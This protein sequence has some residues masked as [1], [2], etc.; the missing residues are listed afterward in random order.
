[1][2]LDSSEH[3][4]LLMASHGAI[5]ASLAFLFNGYNIFAASYFTAIDRPDISLLI[6]A[7]HGLVLIPP[8]IIL[9][10]KVLDIDGIWFATPIA[11]LTTAIVT[12]F[13][14]KKSISDKLKT[15]S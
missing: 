7:L 10:P 15:V 13:L 11:E 9:L 6:A 8:L 4:I 3:E 1:M 12:F 14:M 5:I 2:F